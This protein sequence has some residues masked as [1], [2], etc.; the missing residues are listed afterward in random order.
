M[1]WSWI[2]VDL[3]GPKFSVGLWHLLDFSDI[4]ALHWEDYRRNQ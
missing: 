3:W 2:A 4:G 1:C